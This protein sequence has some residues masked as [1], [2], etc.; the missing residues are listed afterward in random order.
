[1]R[2]CDECAVASM[3]HLRL[4][5]KWDETQQVWSITVSADGDQREGDV[6]AVALRINLGL[7]HFER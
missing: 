4:M 5:S 7:C 6:P 1:M 2:E 3:G